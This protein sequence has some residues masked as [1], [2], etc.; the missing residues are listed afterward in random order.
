MQQSINPGLAST[1]GWNEL[2]TDLAAQLKA[3]GRSAQAVAALGFLVGATGCGTSSREAREA[4]LG[5]V[6]W[7]VGRTVAGSTSSMALQ[8][9]MLLLGVAV[10]TRAC[11]DKTVWDALRDWYTSLCAHTSTPLDDSTP[12]WELE[13]LTAA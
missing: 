10:G 7:I 12:R 11:G 5:G 1:L 13:L 9:P 4:F 3:A 6:R 2:A 8:H